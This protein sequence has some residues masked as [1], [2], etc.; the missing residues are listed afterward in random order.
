LREGGGRDGELGPAQAGHAAAAGTHACIE[1]GV[2]EGA[3]GNRWCWA[4]LAG[5]TRWCTL[6]AYMT[7]PNQ[8]TCGKP[9][10]RTIPGNQ[11]GLPMLWRLPVCDMHN[12]HCT[13]LLLL[14]P[15][16][17]SRE[18][19]HA[20]SCPV[21]PYQQFLPLDPAVPVPLGVRIQPRC[22]PPPRIA[23]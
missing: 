18:L 8:A 7:A 17:T 20:Y 4:W 9:G 23:L 12:V 21:W 3:G 14:Y 15:L 19:A 1:H 11:T 10:I 13:C 16:W 22:A 2:R 6:H 5:N